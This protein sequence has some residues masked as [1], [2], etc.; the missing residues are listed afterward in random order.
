MSN[1]SSGP[2]TWFSGKSAP[3]DQRGPSPILVV[4]FV[5]FLYSPIGALIVTA[6]FIA[7]NYY[8]VSHRVIAGAA[9][10]YCVPYFG[11]VAAFSSMKN[12]FVDYN[13]P[14]RDLITA[15]RTNSMDGWVADN[16]FHW[17]AAQT[18]LSLA[19]GLIVGTLWTSW[20]WI[21][22]PAWEDNERIPGPIHRL[23][24][25]RAIKEIASDV[26]GPVD[27]ATLGVDKY[28]TKVVASEAEAAAH[29]L[30]AGGS[31]AGKTT[32]MMVGI[33]DAIR[34][35]EPVC[36][37]DMKGATDLP[38]QMAEWSQRY[39]R[40]FL[41]WSI[42]DRR[43]GYTGP[44]DGPAFYDPIG[45]GDPS[46]KK[47]LLIGS[48]KWDVEYYK[49]VNENYLQIAFQ[50]AELVPNIQTDAF[51]DLSNLLDTKKLSQRAAALFV[52][53]PKTPEGQTHAAAHGLESRWWE[54]YPTVLDPHVESV[55]SAAADTVVKPEE[56]ERSAIRNMAARVQKLRQSTAGHWLKRDPEHGRDIDLRKVADEGW[57]VVFSLDS[58]NYEATSSQV[59]GLIIQDL[60]TLSSELRVNPAPTPFHVYVDEF[61]AIG[62]DNILGMLARAR[63]A[64]MPCMLSTQAL[65]DL[66]R[67]DPAFLDQALGIVNS[68]IIHR[69]NTEA[70]AEIFA[71]LT[72][73]KLKWIQRMG[74]EKTS[75]LPGGLGTGSGTG[76]G[77]IEQQEDYVVP[78]S[79]F[80]ALKRGECVYIAK[81]PTDRV[82]WPVA[83]IRE[84][85]A[86]VAQAVAAGIAA[87]PVP[88]YRPEPGSGSPFMEAEDAYES[89]E[90]PSPWP[91]MASDV[92]VVQGHAVD[93]DQTLTYTP[94]PLHEVAEDLT[95]VRPS[96]GVIDLSEFDDPAPQT[97]RSEVERQSKAKPTA[98]SRPEEPVTEPALAEDAI[99]ASPIPAMPPVAAP[100]KAPRP[101]V[102]DPSAFRSELPAR[103][104]PVPST[105]VSTPAPSAEESVFGGGDVEWEEGT[106][107]DAADLG[108]PTRPPV[109]LPTSPRR[110][111]LPSAPG[112]GNPTNLPTTKA[113]PSERPMI[114]ESEWNE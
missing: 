105:P 101:P 113:S 9:L 46:R 13:E 31:G 90:F 44:A 87:L 89:D 99:S 15:V 45:R 64:R 68:F 69:A 21:R 106:S 96:T 55:L 85:A 77:T 52:H 60:K 24:R 47:D 14:I 86:L 84:D 83:V 92:D 18:P 62:S 72:G 57:V 114:D 110:A 103:T 95:E 2:T 27:G 41:H 56:S 34:R 30:L 16:W 58:S 71:G 33:R 23:R 107:W 70:D 104:T 37:V 50:I 19:M 67:A 28:G 76:Q 22:R 109:G 4:A 79:G 10:L 54:M 74:V 61:S 32:T 88:T 7:F 25:R 91:V 80:Q 36:V 53:A 39:G 42:T 82:V 6:C 12:M 59:G 108:L 75:G 17:I 51:S 38:A 98:L 1:M 93:Y 102:I 20:K 65:A 8:R 35:G 66:K 26:N 73:K 48:E 11:F 78:A 97:K 112:S 3:E 111:P 5:F 94:R 63:D 40:R 100:P 81:S 43:S 29:C 49:S